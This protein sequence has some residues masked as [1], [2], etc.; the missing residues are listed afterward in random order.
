ML[1]KIIISASVLFLSMVFPVAAD[2]GFNVDDF[3]KLPD[4]YEVIIIRGES[5]IKAAEQC[6]CK[7]AF[8]E[9]NKVVFI[10]DIPK[11]IC[12]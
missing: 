12:I 3:F 8:D 5:A 11:D 6:H 4:K 7:V 10:L 9:K 2:E 1:K